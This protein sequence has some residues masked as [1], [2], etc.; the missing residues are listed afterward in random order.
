MRNYNRIE[1]TERCLI[2]SN[3]IYHGIDCPPAVWNN[4][5]VMALMETS[6]HVEYPPS[7]SGMV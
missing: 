6:R 7:E 3:P 4:R 1:N 2:R 5:K